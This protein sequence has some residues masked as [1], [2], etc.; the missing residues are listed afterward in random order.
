MWAVAVNDDPLFELREELNDEDEPLFGPAPAKKPATGGFAVPP[1][2]ASPANGVPSAPPPL[3]PP[4]PKKP[5]TGQ[6][7]AYQ[8]AT[9]PPTPTRAPTTSPA[10]GL[11]AATKPPTGQ[12][13]SAPA[14]QYQVTGLP[15][16]PPV[17]QRPAGGDPFQEP[18]E[19]RLP[20]GADPEEKLRSFADRG[21]EFARK[22]DEGRKS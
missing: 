19:P 5:T 18:P 16:L 7:G 3:P 20:P 6:T 4:L 8:P 13:A 10:R 12:Y 22:G 14:V 2:G 21:R 1:K 9:S 11:P 15:T 17:V